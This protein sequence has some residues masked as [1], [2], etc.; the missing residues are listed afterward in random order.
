MEPTIGV[1]LQSD[2]REARLWVRA[3]V[4]VSGRFGDDHLE[5]RTYVRLE[6]MPAV[7]GAVRLAY[8]H[9][10]MQL[11]L[12]VVQC[13]PTSASTSTCSSSGMRV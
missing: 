4:Q 2:E 7:R 6:Q 10:R 3:A 12:A 9:V 1:F 11:R 8:H 13:S 5:R